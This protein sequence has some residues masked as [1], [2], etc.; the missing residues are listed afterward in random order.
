[1]SV[2][3]RHGRVADLR[4]ATPLRPPAVQSWL[5]N[6]GHCCRFWRS[7]VVPKVQLAAR[8]ANWR[9]VTFSLRSAIVSLS[10]PLRSVTEWRCTRPGGGG[11]MLKVGR[12]LGVSVHETG[13][14]AEFENVVDGSLGTVGRHRGC[15]VSETGFWLAIGWFAGMAARHMKN[16]PE[17]LAARTSCQSA[18]VVASAVPRHMIA[19]LLTRPFSLP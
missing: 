3:G 2:K 15:H 14:A 6:N 9:S 5:P 1:M 12:F 18:S 16:V 17:T 4:R 7:C 8:S 11:K 13:G 10:F 19:A